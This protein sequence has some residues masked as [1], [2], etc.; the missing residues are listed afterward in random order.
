MSKTT[1]KKKKQATSES[2]SFEKA[3]GQPALDE[4]DMDNNDPSD[5]PKPKDKG[6]S[7]EAC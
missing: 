7:Q 5:K 1:T 4:K 6:S 2:A 3:T